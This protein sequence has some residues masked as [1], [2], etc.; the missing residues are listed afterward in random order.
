MSKI[1]RALL[2]A[3]AVRV[4]ANGAL[5]PTH[6]RTPRQ[7]AAVFSDQQLLLSDG[8]ETTIYTPQ[9]ATKEDARK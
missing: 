3:G 4:E 1:L 2:K 9:K 8:N 7:S 5:T 6:N